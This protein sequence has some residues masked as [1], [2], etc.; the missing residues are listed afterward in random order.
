MAAKAPL[1]KETPF[2]VNPVPLPPSAPI[3]P[4][5]PSIVYAG[6]APA[7]TSWAQKQNVPATVTVP[8]V[9]I[10]EK[11]PVTSS[12]TSKTI[13]NRLKVRILKPIAVTPLP[14]VKIRVRKD[15]K[16]SSKEGVTWIRVRPPKKDRIALAKKI[17]VTPKRN[18]KVR[19][20]N[21][22]PRKRP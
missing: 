20:S 14:V 7:V 18:K 1:P 10:P 19:L 12:E 16:E 22:A 11:V 6:V 9:S 21:R 15:N 8:T 3:S 13:E 17:K 2:L 5:L 4:L